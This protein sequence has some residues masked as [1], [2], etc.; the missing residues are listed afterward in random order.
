MPLKTVFISVLA[1]FALTCTAS[2]QRAQ[3]ETEKWQTPPDAAAKPNPEIN[4]PSAVATGRKVFTRTCVVCHADDGSGQ[5]SRGANLRLREVQAQSDGAL[6]WKISNGNTEH[7][8]PA[9]AGLPEASRWDVVIFLRTLSDANG[10]PSEGSSEHKK[11]APP[12]SDNHKP[13]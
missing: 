10:H 5:D 2:A 9:F 7:G 6:F 11:E 8:M 3:P 12:G 13:Q 1:L 4:N